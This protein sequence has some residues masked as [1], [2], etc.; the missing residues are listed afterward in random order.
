M[1]HLSRRELIAGA[2]GTLAFATSP[3][4]VAQ[5]AKPNIVFILADDMGYADVSCY[6]RPDLNTPNIDRVAANG[7]R[8][9]QAYANS[10]VCT[11]TRTALITGRYQYRLRLG[12]EE[13]L[14]AN[15][16]VGLPPEHPTLPSLLKKAGYGTT[17]IGKWHMGGLPKFGPLKSG[18][19]HFY[20][21]RSGSIDYFAHTAR[22]GRDD[23]WD[24]DVPLHK[25]GYSTDLLGSRVVDAINAYAKAV[26]PFFISLHFNAPHWPWE[27]PGDEAESNRLRGKMVCRLLRGSSPT[28]WVAP[29]SIGGSGVLSLRHFG[30]AGWFSLSLG[31]WV[32]KNLAQRNMEV[33]LRR[34]RRRPRRSQVRGQLRHDPI[35]TA[36]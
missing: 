7:M 20:G 8:F 4:A 11:A 25:V 15:P 35:A 6:G 10:A 21:F 16:N 18:Y 31:A 14:A 27:A 9:L 32:P 29:N 1:S 23:F 28:R 24:E 26:Q 19:D 5:A 2:A 34:R 12:L 36:G 13:P 33:W 22:T 3:N 30:L 17:L